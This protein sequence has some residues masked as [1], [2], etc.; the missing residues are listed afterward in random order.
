ML[1]NRFRKCFR[2]H[3][4]SKYEGRYYV[5]LCKYIFCKLHLPLTELESWKYYKKSHNI[6]HHGMSWIFCIL[7]F[8]FNRSSKIYIFLKYNFFKKYKTRFLHVGMHRKR[9][10][11]WKYPMFSILY[12]SKT[13]F[14]NFW[15][16]LYLLAE[17]LLKHYKKHEKTKNYIFVKNAYIFVQN[18]SQEVFQFLMFMKY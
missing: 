18:A 12:T 7:H 13:R 4:T 8:A 1:F 14:F 17:K 6:K 11:N 16:T 5:E 9:I 10:N 2:N 3:L 15:K